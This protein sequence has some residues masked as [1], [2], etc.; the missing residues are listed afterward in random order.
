MQVTRIKNIYDPCLSQTIQHG[1]QDRRFEMQRAGEQCHE[2]S[3]P[4][5]GSEVTRQDGT[6]HNSLSADVSSAQ[7]SPADTPVR[8]GL[9]QV[10]RWM[11]I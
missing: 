11:G 8:A 1:A 10:G 3:G 7:R 9:S 4:G 6:G 2:L 5:R